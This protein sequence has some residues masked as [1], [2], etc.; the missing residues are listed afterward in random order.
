MLGHIWPRLMNQPLSFPWVAAQPPRPASHL[1]WTDI[2]RPEGSNPWPAP[3]DAWSGF[4]LSQQKHGHWE[5][6]AYFREVSKSMPIEMSV[7]KAKIWFAPVELSIPVT[8]TLWQAFQSAQVLI[9][10]RANS[11]LAT[12]VCTCTCTS[13]WHTTYMYTALDNGDSAVFD[14]ILNSYKPV[15]LILYSMCMTG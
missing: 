9:V 5:I 13:R 6:P 3:S 1:P 10:H 2:T 11:Y 14:T 7:K 15:Q 4:L 12:C 8:A